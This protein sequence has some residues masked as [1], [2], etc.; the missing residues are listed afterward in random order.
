M[1]RTRPI[2][3]SVSPRKSRSRTMSLRSRITARC[4]IAHVFRWNKGS[5]TELGTLPGGRSSDVG[6][7]NARGWIAG[8]SE[9]GEIDPATGARVN[10]AVLWKGNEIVDL[11]TLGEGLNSVA[12]QVNN[13]GQVVGIS[14][15]NIVPDPF[16][17]AGGSIHPFL[18]QNGVMQDLGTLG[19]PDAFAFPG[20]GTQRNN[21]VTGFS[22]IDEVVNPTT[23]FPTVHPFLW[24]DGNMI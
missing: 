11:G 6:G 24:E 23:G 4:S 20:C 14:T 7:I 1:F 13:G 18:W 10:H 9:R 3:A 8:G 16:G 12:L 21:L 15:I 17:F 2:C 22:L 5:L 19:G